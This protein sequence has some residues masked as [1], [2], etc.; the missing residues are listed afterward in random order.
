[1]EWVIISVSIIVIV[2]VTYWIASNYI[3]KDAQQRQTIHEILEM[4]G[5]LD[6]DGPYFKYQYKNENYYLMIIKITKYARFTFNSKIVWEVKSGNQSR[7]LD[8]KVFG[9]LPGKKI[10][11]VYPNQGPYLRYEDEQNIVFTK[12]EVR[13][14][15]MNVISAHEL[16]EILKKGF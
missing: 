16:E 15:N 14:W 13:F 10:V 2:L 4:H 7:L 5:K 8:Q 12:P 1:M 6:A 3:Q 11:I 9:N